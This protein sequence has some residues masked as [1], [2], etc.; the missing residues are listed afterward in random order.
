M[1]PAYPAV[2][3]T[4]NGSDIEVGGDRFA[5]RDAD[6]PLSD[7]HEEN[8]VVC[9]QEG[10][11]D[12]ITRCPTVGDCSQTILLGCCRSGCRSSSS[13]SVL[14]SLTE[15]GIL[16]EAVETGTTRRPMCRKARRTIRSLMRS[17]GRIADGLSTGLRWDHGVQTAAF[18]Y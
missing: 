12:T 10:G 18:I 15:S 13:R 8:A 11:L 6:Y 17:R 2:R 14:G 4:S 9:N 1:S 7:V 16:P 5:L 3:T